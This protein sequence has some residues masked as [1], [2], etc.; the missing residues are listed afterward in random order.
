MFSQC[1]SFSNSSTAF[2]I[3]VLSFG[4]RYPATNVPTPIVATNRPTP[5]RVGPN[6]VIPRRYKPIPTKKVTVPP[7]L[8]SMGSFFE[9]KGVTYRIEVVLPDAYD[10]T[11]KYPIVYMT[12]WWFASKL[13]K[14]LLP[15]L[16]YNIK[17]IIIVGIQRKS[18]I[19]AKDWGIN[20]TRDYTP[21][22]VPEADKEQG[23]PAGTTGGAKHFLSFIK[24]ELI[25]TI[26]KKYPS[27]YENR[28]YV[29]YSYGG[30]FG[31]Y[32][33][34]KKPKLFKKYLLGSPWLK[35]DDYLLS[36]ELKKM[37]P[38]N[39]ESIKSIFIAVE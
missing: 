32:A 5:F 16:K 14:S 26:E 2:V 29:G 24:K 28:G 11:K 30:T 23:V 19:T 7:L 15:I 13:T 12:D 22:N 6:A 9:V 36:K 37:S 38:K 8:Y 39:L 10:V 3:P 20:R 18:S 17:P 35:H 31:T 1:Y 34:L 21:T 25:P 33:L 27:D 4:K